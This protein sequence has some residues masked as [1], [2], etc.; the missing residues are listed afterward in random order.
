MANYLCIFSAPNEHIAFLMQHPETTYNYY[1]GDP[2]EFEESSAS[3]VSNLLQKLFGSNTNTP[4]SPAVPDDWPTEEREIFGPEVNHRNVDLFHCI[5][6][7]TNE[8]VSG[9]GSL[10]QT[11]FS[12]THSAIELDGESFAFKSEQLPE[13]LDLVKA[14]TPESVQKSCPLSSQNYEP[15]LEE[16]QMIVD[17]FQHFAQSLEKTIQQGHGI[18]WV[19]S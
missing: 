4:P 2:P 3:L 1:L 18:I 9:S 16:A 17:E 6:N 8:S 11:W 14:V 7:N 12:P 10:F 13:L 19:S 15:D 5:L